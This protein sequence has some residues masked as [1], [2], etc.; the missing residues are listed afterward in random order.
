VDVTAFHVWILRKRTPAAVRHHV[1]QYNRSVKHCV[2]AEMV[3]NIGEIVFHLVTQ[4]AVRW[5]SIT[6]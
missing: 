4:T 6:C 5:A 2:M 1:Q 3:H